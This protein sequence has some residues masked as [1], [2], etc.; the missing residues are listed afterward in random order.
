MGTSASAP[1]AAGAA[2]LVK[3]AHPAWTATQI[4]QAMRQNVLWAPGLPVGLLDVNA[5]VTGVGL[6]N[7]HIVQPVTI[8]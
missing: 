2:A 8:H 4:V 6:H 7:E 5:L 1:L 3:A